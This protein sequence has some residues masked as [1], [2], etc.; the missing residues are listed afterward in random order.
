MKSIL[1]LIVL[2]GVFCFFVAATWFAA[3]GAVLG[4]PPILHGGP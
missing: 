1:S 4:V 3:V 2:C